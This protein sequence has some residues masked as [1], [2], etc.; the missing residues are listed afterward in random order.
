MLGRLLILAGVAVLSGCTAVNRAGS[1]K[2]AGQPAPAVPAPGGPIR[3][4]GFREHKLPDGRQ[5]WVT[6]PKSR[7]AGESL[8]LVFS[9]HGKGGNGFVESLRW[10]ELAE[11][12]RFIVC[13]PDSAG[14]H[15][16]RTADYVDD[17]ARYVAVLAEL[18]DRYPVD[19]R[20]VLLT[21]FSGGALSAFWT[22]AHRPTLF[23][24][25]AVRSPSWPHALAGKTAELAKARGLPVFIAHGEK[26]HDFT[27]D[28][29]RAARRTLKAAGWQD[30][31]LT[32]LSISGGGHDG[33][34]ALPA[35]VKWFAALPGRGR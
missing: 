16:G 15:S 11:A 18:L 29:V 28:D 8:P 31:D 5:F 4:P 2:P 9:I 27:L 17:Q 21:G 34:A 22:A 32:V 24:A 10:K 20:R 3:D 7:A 23:A 33:S 12:H 26:D 30:A 1:T 13:C 14:S 35:I 25:L 6:V 19:G